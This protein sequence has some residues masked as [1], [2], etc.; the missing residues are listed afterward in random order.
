MINFATLC[1]FLCS[2]INPKKKNHHGLHTANLAKPAAAE[3]LASAN[4]AAKEAAVAPGHE[5]TDRVEILQANEEVYPAS[6]GGCDIT[7]N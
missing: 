1:C 2:A 7:Q 4:V 6:R 3:W 5:A